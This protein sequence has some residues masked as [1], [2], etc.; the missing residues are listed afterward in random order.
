MA[1]NWEKLELDIKTY[2]ESGKDDFERTREKS[3]KVIE[4]LYLTEIQIGATDL[5]LNPVL[6]LTINE[7]TGLH[8]SLER[9]FDSSFDTGEN[10][11]LNQTGIQGAIDH[12]TGAQMGFGIPAAPAMSVGA[13]NTV[14]LPGS[15]FPMNL[16]TTSDTQDLFASE[17]IKAL[18]LHANTI[19]GKFTGLTPTGTPIIVPWLGIL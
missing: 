8:K 1:I 14:S 11:V 4:T 7:A 10:T 6:L 15:I 17:L 18:K 5:F 12:W 9:G 13:N 16:I 3:A 19:E 2:L